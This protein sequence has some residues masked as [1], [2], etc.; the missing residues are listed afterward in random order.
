MI[1]TL[2]MIP[3]LHDRE[4]LILS[5]KDNNAVGIERSNIVNVRDNRAF[6][7]TNRIF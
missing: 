6:D 2:S 3:T 7:K 5:D 4:Y 1:P